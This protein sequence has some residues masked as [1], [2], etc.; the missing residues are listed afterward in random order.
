[1]VRPLIL[2]HSLRLRSFPAR[3]SPGAPDPA[4]GVP[5]FLELPAGG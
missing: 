2:P 1:M 3:F 4:N 5:N